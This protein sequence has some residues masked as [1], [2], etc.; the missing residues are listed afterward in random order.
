MCIWWYESCTLH[1]SVKTI[2]SP[3]SISMVCSIKGYHWKLIFIRKI[4]ATLQVSDSWAL[5]TETLPLYLW[6]M[7][8]TPE[9]R[10]SWC[11]SCCGPPGSLA[12]AILREAVQGKWDHGDLCAT[13]L[14]PWAS[15]QDAAVR[16]V[17]R[18]GCAEGMQVRHTN[19][20]IFLLQLWPQRQHWWDL[21]LTAR[22]SLSGVNISLFGSSST[23]NFSSLRIDENHFWQTEE[24]RL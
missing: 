17:G 7:L 24:R 9:V 14:A 15:P 8:C 12:A 5:P 11:V 6:L 2:P 19:K 13:S 3:T 1:R 23:T 16:S 18:H 10:V 20:Y 22:A 4:P 21:L